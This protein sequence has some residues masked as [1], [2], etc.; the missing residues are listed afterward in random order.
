MTL[1][2]IF[3]GQRSGLQ[4][5]AIGLG[6]SR[7]GS[8]LSGCTGAAAEQLVRHALD[9][10]V[11]LFDTADIYGQGESERLVG[12]GLRGRR[13]EAVIVTKAGQR[14]T[15]AQR[16]VALAKAPLRQLARR[17]PGLKEA[18]ASRRAAP[19]PR[20]YSP[21][22]LQRAIEGSLRRLQVERIDLFLLHSP[23]ADT[24]ERGEFS[25]L[26][27][28]MVQQGK[29]RAWGVSCDDAACVR[30]ALRRPEVAAL[31]V[32]L[33]VAEAMR[34]ELEAAAQRGVG[35]MLREIFAGRPVTAAGREA[36][37]R[38][39]LTFP[40]ALALVGTTSAAHLDEALGCAQRTRTVEAA[41]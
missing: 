18:I 2:N 19:L 8:T 9:S 15:P 13:E 28:R 36:A 12:A 26:L 7:L 33:D 41:S 30:A 21:A 39:A 29:L 6:C 1:P 25:E 35:L 14:F 32:P 27:N 4:A 37:I 10:G 5:S 3:L 11:T 24:V 38:A 23:A 34:P 20:D 22:H 40:Q 16:M 31:Q 17:L